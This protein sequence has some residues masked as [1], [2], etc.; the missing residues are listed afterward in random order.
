MTRRVI[1]R[2]VS[3]KRCAAGKRF[4]AADSDEKVSQPRPLRLTKLL[5]LAL[6][7]QQLLDQ[8]YVTSRAELAEVAQVSRARLSQIMNLLFLASDIQEEILLLPFTTATREPVSER[9][10]RAITAEP[11]W[12]KQREMWHALQRSRY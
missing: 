5:A 1:H 9:D 8:G 6:R 11:I 10:M 3:I 2:R 7:Y 12:E 4:I